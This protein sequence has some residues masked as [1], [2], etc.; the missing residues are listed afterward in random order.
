MGFLSR[1]KKN[2]EPAVVEETHP[3]EEELQGMEEAVPERHVDDYEPEYV[4]LE[5]DGLVQDD[6]DDELPTAGPV[7]DE[8]PSSSQ[9][10][11]EEYPSAPPADESPPIDAEPPVVEAKEEEPEAVTPT[12]LRVEKALNAESKDDDEESG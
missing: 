12:S 4:E 9:A 8:Y 11:G 5:Q 2:R 6:F 7:A 3:L 1:K 10:A